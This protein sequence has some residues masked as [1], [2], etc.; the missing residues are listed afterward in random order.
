MRIAITVETLERELNGK[1]W[2]GLNLANTDHEVVLAKENRLLQSIDVVDPDILI[3]GGTFSEELPLKR[4]LLKKYKE[5]SFTVVYFDTEGAVYHDKEAYKKRIFPE[6][7]S[8]ADYIFTWGNKPGEIAKQMVDNTEKVKV[9]GCPRFDFL[10]QDLSMIYDAHANALEK[11]YS[12]YIL[13]NTNFAHTNHAQDPSEAYSH[14]PTQL[15]STASIQKCILVHA[16]ELIK[17]LS[18]STEYNIVVR[19]HPSENYD[20]YNKLFED[21]ND[22]FV[23]P[24]G[25]VRSWIKA[26]VATIH[27]GSTT[28]IESALLRKPT[29]VFLPERVKSTKYADLLPNEVSM[30]VSSAPELLREL[31][32]NPQQ[33]MQNIDFIHQTLKPYIHNVDERSVDNFVEEIEK[34]KINETGREFSPSTVEKIKRIATAVGGDKLI[35]KIQQS[36]IRDDWKYL[37]QKFPYLSEEE[38]RNRVEMF[39]PHIDVSKIKIKKIRRLENGF[40]LTK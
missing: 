35:N 13:F 16:V 2:L 27:S 9:T 3:C 4:K 33:S 15:D 12:K 25:E 28:G 22:I 30:T 7:S 20:T 23:C 21:E 38:F 5:C 37:N 29:F 1:I 40:M 39:E 11:R 26:S 31:E 18:Q 6:P 14:E 32:S 17:E 8:S 10:H 24:E 36:G 34:I 19:P